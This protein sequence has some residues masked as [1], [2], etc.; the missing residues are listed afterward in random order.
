MTFRSYHIRVGPGGQRAREYMRILLAT[1]KPGALRFV[2]GLLAQAGTR[3]CELVE[4]LDAGE[5]LEALRRQ[6]FSAVL[7]FAPIKKDAGFEKWFEFLHQA[8]QLAPVMV[9]SDV[10]NEA[11]AAQAL[12][13][14]AQDFLV[15]DSL[16]PGIL[17]RALRSGIERH[18]VQ[19]TLR[20]TQEKLLLQSTA[21][22]AAANS[23]IITN[24]AGAILWANPAFAVM[25]GYSIEEALGQN[26]RFLKSGRHDGEFYRRFWQT[27]LAGETWRGEFI[28]RRKDGTEY[29]NEQTVT[30]VRSAG[31]EI[32][33]FIGVSQD[34]TARRRAAEEARRLGEQLEHMV[35]ERTAQLESA[36]RELEAFAFSV[37][38]DLRAPLRHIG[39]FADMLL[40]SA[41][42]VL[43]EE[44]CNYIALIT[45]SARRMQRL[46]DDL[47]VLSR[48]GRAEMKLQPLDLQ[49]LVKE[50]IGQLEPEINSRNVQWKQGP[51]PLVE[52][53]PALL[54]QVLHNLLSNAVKYTRPRERAE[55][56][57]GCSQDEPGETILYVR[58][59]GVGFDMAY[60][61]KLFGVFQRLHSLED[62]EGTGVGLANVRRIIA[63]H[64]GRTWAEAKVD[65][66]ATFYFSLPKGRNEPAGGSQAARQTE[67]QPPEL[68]PFA[69]K[70]GDNSN[71]APATGNIPL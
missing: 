20:N 71:T 53:D 34:I 44:C 66:G 43:S 49:G 62:F 46:I 35:R 6:K 7:L 1:V 54:R 14:G 3:D 27:I 47:L 29:V 67:G 33:H 23:V 41:G 19:E 59:N 69:S 36:N 51:L 63:R 16:A 39:G 50:V 64:G 68:E 48:S 58:D 5:G 17:V 60:A 70:Q 9:V 61:D 22:A 11:M 65:E 28:N 25:T 18:R 15:K 40:E 30:P 52:A 38:H 26:P 4:T 55:I 37:S 2:G 12:D 32:T 42:A 10:E 21:L 24:R 45:G 57:I 56:E 31:G 8:Q 13:H